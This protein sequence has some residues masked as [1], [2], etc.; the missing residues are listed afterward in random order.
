MQ[1]ECKLYSFLLTAKEDGRITAGHIA[2]FAALLEK[3]LETSKNKEV[4][5]F[6][7]EIMHLAKISSRRTYNKRM[8]EL[9]EFGYINYFPSFHQHRGT[10]IQFM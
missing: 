2:L 9:Q 7:Q 8:K 1:N 5:I 4:K 10:L 3:S 6:R